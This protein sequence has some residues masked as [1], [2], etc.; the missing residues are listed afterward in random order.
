MSKHVENFTIVDDKYKQLVEKE[1]GKF[2]RLNVIEVGIPKEMIDDFYYCDT[3][4]F[5][6]TAMDII[7]KT[8]PNAKVEFGDV[9]EV[10]ITYNI[11]K[12]G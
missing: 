5:F 12:R 3:D 1:N 4:T 10:L 7:Y 6:V 11:V 8:F 9:D 2:T